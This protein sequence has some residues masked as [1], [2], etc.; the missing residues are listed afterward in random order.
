[1]A[2]GVAGVCKAAAF[3]SVHEGGRASP[4]VVGVLVGEELGE[5]IANEAMYQQHHVS[6][7]AFGAPATSRTRR[8]GSQGP[9]QLGLRERLGFHTF[10]RGDVVQYTAVQD[11]D[12]V[13]SAVVFAVVLP[14][15]REAEQ[16]RKLLVLYDQEAN[17][18]FSASGR[19]GSEFMSHRLRTSRKTRPPRPYTSTTTEGC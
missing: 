15:K 5:T 16:G 11:S 18:F 4:K 8:R 7:A 3:S 9:P 1:M 19:N 14:L 12:P 2:D 6:V 13:Y 17:F 10:R